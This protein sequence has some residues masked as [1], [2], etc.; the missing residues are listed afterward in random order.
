MIQLLGVLGIIAIFNG[1]AYVA[2]G[3]MTFGLALTAFGSVLLGTIVAAIQS[4]KREP[5]FDTRE[6]LTVRQMLTYIND[7]PNMPDDTKVYVGDQGLNAAGS[8]FS[9]LLDGGKTL[10]IE[11]MAEPGMVAESAHDLF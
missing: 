11:R 1:G 5:R 10:V 8:V 4:T 7:H 2:M 6:G 9:C 3:Q